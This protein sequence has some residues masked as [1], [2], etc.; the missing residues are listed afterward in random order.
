MRAFGDPNSDEARQYL[1]D[2]R[3]IRNHP[4]RHGTGKRNA[5]IRRKR[6]AKVAQANAIRW[7]DRGKFL[8]ASRAYWR[9]EADQH[10]Y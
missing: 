1:L 4:K 7:R 3:C 5:R 10:P 2:R 8:D 6:K 9:G